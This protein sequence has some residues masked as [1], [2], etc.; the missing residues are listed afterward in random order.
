MQLLKKMKEVVIDIE[1][2][3]GVSESIKEAPFKPWS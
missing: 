2:E 3:F 1:K